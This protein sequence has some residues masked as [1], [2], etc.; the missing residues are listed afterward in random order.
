MKQPISS[1]WR[2][3]RIQHS[4]V[5]VIVGLVLELPVRWVVRPDIPYMVPGNPWFNLPLR[6][7]VE[8]AFVLAVLAVAWIMKIRLPEIGIPLRRWTRW[9]WVAFAVVGAIELAI[10]ISI[11]GQR[12]PRL[13]AAGVLGPGLLWATGEFLFGFNQEFVFRGA[14]M[15]GLLR[16]GGYWWALFLN[17]LVFLVG[18]LHGPGLWRMAPTSPGAAIGMFAGVVA[19]GLFFSWLRYRSDNVILCSILHGIVNGFLNGAAFARR[20]Y[21]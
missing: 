19:T 3:L 10:V 16:L 5:L 12:W 4:W 13:Y 20:A 17:T 14:L 15:T 6:I 1:H 18:P 21:L 11:A 2:V 9:E 7:G 8:L